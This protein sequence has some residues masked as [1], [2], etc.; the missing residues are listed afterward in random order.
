VKGAFFYAQALAPAMIER[1][2][3]RIINISSRAGVV[4]IRNHVAYSA[5]KA[6][7]NLM[8]KI[9]MCT[10][11]SNRLSL[12]YEQWRWSLTTTPLPLN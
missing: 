7:M 6:A 11:L 12:L 10:L 8:T 9:R 4:G 2:F 5:S 3:G 1:G